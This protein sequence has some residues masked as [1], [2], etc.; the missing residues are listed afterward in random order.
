MFIVGNGHSGFSKKIAVVNIW[1]RGHHG[2]S[3]EDGLCESKWIIG[4]NRIATR[5]R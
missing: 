3:M 2:L 4:F 5:L 1:R